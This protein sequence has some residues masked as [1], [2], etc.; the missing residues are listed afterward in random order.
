MFGTVG[1][2]ILL[3]DRASQLRVACMEIRLV[4]RRRAFVTQAL[5]TAGDNQKTSLP[6]TVSIA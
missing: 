4:L 1:S 3:Q 5:Y 6:K 2:S